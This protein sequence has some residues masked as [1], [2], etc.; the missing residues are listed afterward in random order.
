MFASAIDIPQSGPLLGQLS[1]A[2]P[3]HA[4]NPPEYKQS[5]TSA[6]GVTEQ[7][8]YLEPNQEAPLNGKPRSKYGDGIGHAEVGTEMPEDPLSVLALA[9]T[10][11]DRNREASEPS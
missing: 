8:T 2:S 10:M 1:L 9:G 3:T 4:I 11:V 7:R 6:P 5:R